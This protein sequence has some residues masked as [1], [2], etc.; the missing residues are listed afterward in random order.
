MTELAV[1]VLGPD[2]P[3]IVAA[4]TEVL[5]SDR[6]N[7]ADASMHLLRGQFAMTLVVD[8]P[9][10]AAEV[11]ADLDPVALRFG[12]LVSVREV[13]PAPPATG[14]E[15]SAWVV[16]VHG[17]DQPGLVHR[18]TALLAAH[19]GNLTDLATRQAGDLYALVAGLDLP[20]DR[21]PAELRADLAGLAEQL[22]VEISAAPADPDLL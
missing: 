5:L 3:G 19:A 16:R 13:D 6:G 4:V 11:A 21:D 15:P 12:L 18:V 22:G 9:T 17:A 14:P 2:R 8:V 1:A 20:A 10:S 7:L